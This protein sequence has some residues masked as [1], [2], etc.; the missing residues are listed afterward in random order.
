MCLERVPIHSP[1][2]QNPQRAAAPW[3]RPLHPLDMQCLHSDGC[4]QRHVGSS[5]KRKILKHNS[6]AAAETAP[7]SGRAHRAPAGNVGASLDLYW[8]RRGLYFQEW[9]VWRDR[10]DSRF[11]LWILVFRVTPRD[12]EEALETA[13]RSFQSEQTEQS[14]LF[15]QGLKSFWFLFCMFPSSFPTLSTFRA[16]EHNEQNL[17]AT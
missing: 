15:M 6:K 3:P 1:Q 9:S 4:S 16:E 2:Q 5:K 11:T 8:K 14:I 7:P 12:P 17:S 13:R 10:W